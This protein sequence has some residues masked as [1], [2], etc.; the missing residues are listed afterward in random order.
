[1]HM[2]AQFKQKKKITTMNTEEIDEL[3][4]HFPLNTCKSGDQCWILQC[5][6]FLWKFLVD[7]R[8][9]FRSLSIPM[10]CWVFTSVRALIHVGLV[11]IDHEVQLISTKGTQINEIEQIK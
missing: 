5:H 4:L 9:L 10:K 8:C 7:T 6:A 1:M 11:L 2:S 3:Y